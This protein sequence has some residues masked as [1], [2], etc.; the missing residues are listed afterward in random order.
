MLRRIARLAVCIWIA[1]SGVAMSADLPDY[2][3]FDGTG[4]R[5]QNA[6]V[7]L[8]LHGAGGSGPQVRRASGFDRWARAARVVAINSSGEDRLWNDG[9]FAGNARKAEVAA[10]D[11]VGRLL[12]LV[13]QV[14]AG[15]LGN[16]AR[17][18]VIGHSNGGGMA[19][20]MACERPDA[21]AGIAVIAT[22]ILRDVPCRQA[23]MPVPTVFFCGTEDSTNPHSGRSDSGSRRDR[24]L[25]FSL[26]AEAIIDVRADRNGCTRRGAAILMDTAA[27]GV[28]VDRCDWAGY[29][30]P[31]R[32]FEVV[33]GGHAWPGSRGGLA[34]LSGE[35]RVRDVDAGREALR[36]FAGS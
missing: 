30:A 22:K 35:A 10:R 19:M 13:R 36:L 24:A 3:V 32:Y 1:A 8:V 11:D 5:G 17:L 9:R 34:V 23:A 28:H 25:G 27:D 21:V 20:R 12:A 7:V 33:G 6:P 29:R 2:E 4:G 16:P 18:F 15:G 26:S 14:A 31:L